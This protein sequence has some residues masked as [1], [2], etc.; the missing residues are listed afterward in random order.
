MTTPLQLADIQ[1][2]VIVSLGAG[3][4]VPTVQIAHVDRFHIT[5][6]S[7]DGYRD[8]V[9]ATLYRTLAEKTAGWRAATPNEAET[10]RRNSRPAPENWE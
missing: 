7:A 8:G 10:F 2:G 5:Y 4:S 6:V 1:P 9:E 3:P